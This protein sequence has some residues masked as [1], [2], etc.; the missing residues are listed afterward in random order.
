MQSSHLCKKFKTISVYFFAAIFCLNVACANTLRWAADAESGVPNVFYDPLDSTKLTGFEYEIAK[1]IAAELGQK[2]EFYANDWEMLVPGLQRKQYDII[3]NA[4][5]EKTW[6]EKA[7]RANISLTIP[8][9]TTELQLVVKA[10]DETITKAS[11]LTGK[12]VGILKQSRH[13]EN[14][15]SH[16]KSVQNVVYDDE[17]KAYADLKIGRLDAVLL[18][19]PESLYYVEIEKDVKLVNTYIGKIKYAIMVRDDDVDLLNNLN[20]AIEQIKRNGILKSILEKWGLWNEYMAE[21][22]D[23]PFCKN[24]RASEFENYVAAVKANNSN[25]YNFY[26]SCIPVFFKAAII[27]LQLSVCAMIFAML[28][29]F[30]LA[31]LKT[32]C[33]GPIRWLVTVYVE[34]IRGTPLLIQLLLIFYGLPTL[35]SYLPESMSSYVCLSPFISGVVALA[36]NY[37][38]YE[39]EI[40]RAGLLSVPKGQMEAARALGMTHF[41]ALWHVVFP[42]AARIVIPPVTNNFIML[43][44]D[45]SL[46]SMITI[47]EL[48]RS[49]QYLAATNFN[50]LGTGVM[51]AAVYL[52]LGFPFVRLAKKFEQHLSY[53]KQGQ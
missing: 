41:Q 2:L 42:Q 18:D 48:T 3:L 36:V 50:Y 46:V 5:A 44:Q 52:L 11:D 10:N 32:Y 28:M 33:S 24:I 53:K 43:L 9:Y 6:Q 13:A 19:A 45:S 16:I 23:I 27:T 25:A 7:S 30:V 20:V 8:Y 40:Y 35:A 26:M 37:S 38:S 34:C 29:G 1:A 12:R 4:I 22:Y 49:Y 47:V 17:V 39:A 14:A 51:V 21:E 31:V 15:L